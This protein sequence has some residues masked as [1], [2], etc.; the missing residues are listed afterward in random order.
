MLING[1]RYD[2]HA[3]LYALL[4]N[5]ETM[6]W[7][8]NQDFDYSAFVNFRQPS[9][10]HFCYSVFS[11]QFF[12]IFLNDHFNFIIELIKCYYWFGYCFNDFFKWINICSFVFRSINNWMIT[13]DHDCDCVSPTLYSLLSPKKYKYYY[14]I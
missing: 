9:S 13:D 6:L 1:H 14:S 7:C 10:C 5:V 12:I 4:P 3:N 11:S 2:V 8:D